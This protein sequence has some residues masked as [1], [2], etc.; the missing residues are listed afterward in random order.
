MPDKK[1]LVVDDEED[2]TWSIAKHLSKDSD[3]YSLTTVND[4]DKA[5]DVLTQYPVDLVITDIR[6]P[7]IS[8][9][10]LLLQ[11]KENYP[12]TKVIIMT[13]Y[14]SS[15]VQDEAN[16]R[17]CF[18]YIEKP[19]EIKELR[20]LILSALQ[21]KKGFDGQISDFNLSDL[22][23]MN[24]LGRLTNA[25]EVV[26]DNQRGI[27]YFKDGNIVHTE[28]GSMEGEEA[29]YEI[30]NWQGGE[31]SVNRNVTPPKESIMKGWQTLL[32]EGLRRSDER[33]NKAEGDDKKDK[34]SQNKKVLLDRLV[35]QKGFK[36]VA[37]FDAEGF[38]VLSSTAK[39][40]A[41]K[42]SVADIAPLVTDLKDQISNI[43]EAM[44]MGREQDFSLAFENGNVYLR[45]FEKVNEY[46][47]IVADQTVTQSLIRMEAKK[48]QKNFLDN[49]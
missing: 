10:D 48:L 15:E 35:E 2:L 17:G 44:E 16:R 6:M 26:N 23:Q 5:L 14:G 49:N 39:K 9:L 29:F 22:I 33:R 18:K 43:K 1:V 38:P 3:K 34:A 46:L 11:I 30:I 37:V 25:L 32:L 47:L 13:A 36:V 24:C 31:F 42:I 21:E 12:N 20:Q 8:G 41:A 45:S 27:I 19:F 40:D 28:L 7:E 4:G